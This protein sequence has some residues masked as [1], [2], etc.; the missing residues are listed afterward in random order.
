MQKI[1]LKII[2]TLALIIIGIVAISSAYADKPSWGGDGKAEKHGHK[3]KHEWDRNEGAFHNRDMDDWRRNEYFGDRH[4]TIV[5]DYYFDQFLSGN[6]PPGLA[7][8]HNGCMP[9]GQARKWAIGRPLPRDV[10][11][12][13]LPPEVI[14]QLGPPLPGYRYV[15]VANDILLITMGTGMVVDAIRDLGWH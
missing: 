3:E 7:K 4:R 13:D 11:Y 6:C 5:H 15:R 10:I 12:Y 2:H 14:M 9:P 1:N 8:K